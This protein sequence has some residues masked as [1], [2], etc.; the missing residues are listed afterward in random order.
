MLATYTPPRLTPL[1]FEVA[2]ATLRWALGDH[3]ASPSVDQLALACA[4]CA[5]ETGRW[6][7]IWNSNFGN[8]KAGQTYV[9]MYTAFQCGEELKDGSWV[10]TPEGWETCVSGKSKGIRRQPIIYTG[11]PRD[12][13]HPQTRFRAFANEWDGAQAYVLTLQTRF[14]AAYA[15]LLTG[16]PAKFV[17]ALK[18]S[19]YFTADEAQYL[20]GVESLFREFKAKLQGLPHEEVD[21]DDGVFRLAEMSLALWLDRQLHPDDPEPNA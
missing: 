1:K 20:R 2:A 9:G 4:K 7:K 8:V 12:D 10:F 6:Q 17:H 11:P 21:V 19:N 5:L 14:P 3:Q 18:V 15:G 13:W 16:D